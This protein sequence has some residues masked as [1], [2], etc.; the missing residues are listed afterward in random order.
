MRH[1]TRRGQSTGDSGAPAWMTGEIPAVGDEAAKPADED[2][3]NVTPNVVKR[4]ERPAAEEKPAVAAPVQPEPEVEP[5]PV[6]AAEPEPAPTAPEPE[7]APADPIADADAAAAVAALQEV[8]TEAPSAP[9]TPAWHDDHDDAE[10]AKQKAADEEKRAKD[11]AAAKKGEDKKAAKQAKKDAKKQAAVAADEMPKSTTGRRLAKIA[12]ALVVVLALVAGGG[13]VAKRQGWLPSFVT[14]A[15]KNKKDFSNTAG[16]EDVLVTIPDNS[17]LTNFGQILEQA[18]VVGSVDAFIKA[19]DGK[20]LSGGVY[21]MRKGIPAATA[22]EMMTGTDNRVGRLVVPEGVQLEAKRGVDRKTIPGV[23]DLIADATEVELN[24]K[25]VGVTVE[26]LEQAAKTASA[27]E[28]G[29]PSWARKGVAALPGDYR[30][31]EGLI[32]PGTWEAV[33]PEASAA[34]I[35]NQL[36]SDSSRR[37]ESWGLLTGNKSGLSPYEV[38][39][40]ASINEREVRHPE[41]LP[42]VARVI[43]NRLAKNQRLEMDSTTNYTAAETNIDVHGDNYKADT[44]WNTYKIFGLPPTPIATVG[45]QALKAMLDPPKGNWLYFLTVDKNG[46]TLFSENFDEHVRKRQIAC[47]NGFLKTGC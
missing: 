4:V 41:D 9:A 21:K 13:Y 5:E 38:L 36:I 34:E 11:E 26:Q 33:N 46:K 6:V 15:L 16:T 19:S 23:F 24:G 22:V 12:T 17:S 10:R 31:L 40:A 1:R 30:R 8:P 2:T 35:L 45:E 42:K 25:K 7:P 43:L 14:N 29:V 27:D 3:P 39:I 32:A 18:G 47:D 20:A 37:Y 44:Q 28:L